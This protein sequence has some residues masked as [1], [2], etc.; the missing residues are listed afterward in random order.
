MKYCREPYH[1]I[2][3]ALMAVVPDRRM[4]Y[5]QKLKMLRT[6]RLTIVEALRQVCSIGRVFLINLISDWWRSTV[7]RILVYDRRTFPALRHDVQLTGDLPGVNHL[8]YV[9]Q[10]GQSS[11]SSSWGR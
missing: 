7:V 11:L 8:L 6:N 2:R 10:H 3:Y 1:D 4:Q 9:S 5:E